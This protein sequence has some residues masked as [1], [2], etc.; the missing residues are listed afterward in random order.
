MRRI[1]S[2]ILT[3]AMLVSCFGMTTFAADETTNVLPGIN[4][5]ASVTFNTGCYTPDEAV[6][7][8]AAAEIQASAANGTYVPKGRYYTSNVFGASGDNVTSILMTNNASTDAKAIVSMN[9]GAVFGNRTDLLDTDRIHYGFYLNL[10]QGSV[11][12]VNLLPANAGGISI[13][14]DLLAGTKLLNNKL[15][16]WVRFDIFYQPTITYTYTK[17]SKT[18]ATDTSTGVWKSNALQNPRNTSDVAS[19][20]DFTKMPDY[21]ENYDYVAKDTVH[22]LASCYVNGE[23]VLVDKTAK[24]GHIGTR[25]WD[26]LASRLAFFGNGVFAVAM[27]NVELVRN[28]DADTYDFIDYPELASGEKYRVSENNLIY[29]QPITAADITAPAGFTVAAYSD[30]ACTKPVTGVISLGDTVAVSNGPVVSYYAANDGK[31]VITTT[32]SSIKRST[33]SE[34]TSPLAGKAAPFTKIT[35]PNT[36]EDNAFF[37][38]TFGSR[39]PSIDTEKY[40]V[41]EMN[42][43]P[44]SDGAYLYIGG[45]QS[46][47]L[48]VADLTLT[49]S[50]LVQNQWNKIVVVLENGS[51]E[52]NPYPANKTDYASAGDAKTASP[53]T[54]SLYCNGKLINDKVKTQL[55]MIWNNGGRAEN[56]FRIQVLPKNTTAETYAYVDDVVLYGTDKFTAADA[57]LPVLSSVDFGTID[58]NTITTAADASVINAVDGLTVLGKT[59]GIVNSGDVIAYES[60]NDVAYYKV[61]NNFFADKDGNSASLGWDVDGTTLRI[62]DI[63]G[64]GTGRMPS[65]AGANNTNTAPWASVSGITDIVIEDG[66]THVGQWTVFGMKNLNSV[67]FPASVSAFDAYAINGS[68]ITNLIFEEGCTGFNS[69]CK[70]NR[71]CNITNVYLPS[72][73]KNIHLNFWRGLSVNQAGKYPYIATN[74]TINFYAPSDSEAY[75]WATT[76]QKEKPADVTV[77]ISTDCS[78]RLYTF[79]RKSYLSGITV[80]NGKAAL[81]AGASGDSNDTSIEC[82][83]TNADEGNAFISGPNIDATLFAKRDYAVFEADVKFTENSRDFYYGSNQHKN[84][85]PTIYSDNVLLLDGWNRVMT[86]VETATGN[87]KTYINGLLYVEAPGAVFGENTNTATRFVFYNNDNG[88][89]EEVPVGY[90]DNMAIYATDVNP[91]ATFTAPLT[92]T[93]FDAVAGVTFTAS[94]DVK[95]LKSNV[96][97]AAAYNGD[98]MVGN[99]VIGTDS[100]TIAPVAGATKYVGYVW[101]SIDGLV[102][103]AASLAV[104]VAQ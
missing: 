66:I 5:G 50:T 3:V 96:V 71:D 21:D 87:A 43:L 81:G 55:G 64:V 70:I 30:T 99:V 39:Y 78:D 18:D 62:Y 101:N 102:P 92:A 59:E 35:K 90:V 51:T 12:N 1:F 8:Q 6:W 76:M 17:T 42:Y 54:L 34:Y 74:K 25:D 28:F 24:S 49:N 52:A 60:G 93:A 53:H 27:Q 104:D 36:D 63:P 14:P 57:A 32:M 15:G 85:S 19:G 45:Q 82:Y 44:E 46:T 38:V 91:A 56:F 88:I 80:S 89:S 83:S 75:T 95:A 77:N 79:V 72:T 47:G 40:Y 41:L 103:I 65:F 67:T 37:E 86:V 11:N 31:N 97:I 84:I 68:T 26:N 22:G 48:G 73:A 69:D 98:D 29:N 9:N 94:A 58:G 7:T 61:K 4:T 33:H 13:T 20:V 16:Q 2:I 10:L 23:P 100:V